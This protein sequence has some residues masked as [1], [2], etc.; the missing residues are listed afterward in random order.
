MSANN[1][2]INSKFKPF[3]Y[4][5][6]L[7]SPQVATL[8]HQAIENEYTELATKANVWDGLANKQTDPDAYKMYKTYSDDLKGYADQL[9][10][11]GLDLMSR[12]NMLNM[13]ERYS[14]DITPIEVAYKRRQ[15]LADEQR[16]LLAQDNTLMFDRD[17]S[18][19]SLDEL[20]RNPQLSYQSYSGATLAKQVGTAAQS[21]A[22]EMRNNP[23]KWR[24]ILGNQ[25]FE[26]ITQE[27]YRPEEIIKVI[28]NNSDASPVLKN[29][30]EDAVK[31]SNI[32]TWGNE[33]T[34]KRAYE[35]AGQGLWNAVG[36]SKYE[37]LS[38]KAYDYA[39]QEKLA[40]T[41]AEKESTSPN[42]YYR[43]VPKTTIDQDKKTTDLYNDLEFIQEVMNDPSILNKTE[44][45][46][47]TTYDPM[48][49]TPIDGLQPVKVNEERLRKLSEKY[50]VK[51]SINNINGAYTTN[52]G[53]LSE[54]LQQDIRSSAVRGFSY[55]PNITS[56]DLIT[57]VLK[58]N[59]RSYYRR[60]NNTGLWELD[61]NKKGDEVDID[62]LKNYFTDDADIDFDPDLGFIINATKDGTTR[63]AVIDTELIDDQY[64]TF[65]RA[66][67]S[68]QTALEYG[69]DQ[70]ATSLIE[71]VMK[72]FYMKYNTLEKRQSNTDNK[73]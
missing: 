59:V 71:A 40:R 48:Y 60:S 16:K 30:V 2:I 38:N 58:E 53:E 66:Q 47:V 17:A 43:A 63:S 52:L 27:G 4:A 73:M 32:A 51:I 24:K 12:R 41:K 19:I 29:I 36:K 54:K 72:A 21:L 57:Q 39:M 34:L 44:N 49:G 67:Q 5:E 6:M 1:I 68:I 56:S 28:Q 3:S 70:L 45:V 65:S 22:T 11:K 69:E 10:R 46:S 61:D 42:L 26:A 13:R 55:K 31:S 35:Y 9:L 23:R 18:T 50:G 25:Y 7:Q 64:R 15:E 8:A 20:I 62:N 33:N 14:S 37:T